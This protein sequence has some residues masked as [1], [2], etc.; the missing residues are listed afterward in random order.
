MKPE[1]SNTYCI[2][3]GVFR[4]LSENLP[5]RWTIFVVNKVKD[6]DWY[7]WPMEYEDCNDEDK[8]NYEES[9]N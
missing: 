2:G 3:R 9:G 5:A 4:D 8:D 1:N 7:L 6:D